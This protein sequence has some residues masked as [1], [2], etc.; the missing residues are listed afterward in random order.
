MGTQQ[1]GLTDLL[2]ADLSKDAQIL[3]LARDAAQNLLQEDPL[4]EKPE[5]SMIL[6]QVQSQRKHEMNWSRI[7]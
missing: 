2:I 6:R 7:S 5:N 3:T 1:S 4:L